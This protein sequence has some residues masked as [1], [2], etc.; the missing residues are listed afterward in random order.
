LA[1]A[2]VA[3]AIGPSQATLNAACGPSEAITATMVPSCL[4][5]GA[6]TEATPRNRSPS[7]RDRP[8]ARISSNRAA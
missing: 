1:A 3:R 6:A 7:T 4:N 2:L 8:W 5:T